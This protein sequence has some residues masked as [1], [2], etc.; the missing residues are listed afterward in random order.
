VAGG[1]NEMLKG[2][3]DAEI[4]RHQQY[5]EAAL[6]GC[7]FLVGNTFTA[8]DIQIAWVLELAEARGRMAGYTRLTDYLARM[9]ARPAYQRALER[10]GKQTL[11]SLS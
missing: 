2:Y 3:Y 4:V 1:G 5:M 8:A 7:E 10:G 11:L 9:R 6:D